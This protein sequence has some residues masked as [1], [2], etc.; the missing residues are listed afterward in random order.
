VST[1][2]SPPDWYLRHALAANLTLFE[3]LSLWLHSLGATDHEIGIV[4]GRKE[5]GVVEALRR[6]QGKMAASPVVTV[7]VQGHAISSLRVELER[8]AREVLEA[9]RN[10]VARRGGTCGGEEHL[11]KVRPV[12]VDDLVDERLRRLFGEGGA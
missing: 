10:E 11:P 3:A 8:Q 12:T 6:A 7:D 9:L 5:R 4:L 2:L 1:L